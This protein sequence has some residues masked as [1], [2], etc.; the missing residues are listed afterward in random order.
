MV[1]K[2]NTP[3]TRLAREML[4]HQVRL[5]QEYWQAFDHWKSNHPLAAAG[6][7]ERLGREEVHERR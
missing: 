6:A 2:E 7:A 4:D 5:S 3:V 1:E